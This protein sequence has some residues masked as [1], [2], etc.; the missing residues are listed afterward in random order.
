MLDSFITFHIT[1]E[2]VTFGKGKWGCEH[3]SLKSKCHTVK[4]DKGIPEGLNRGRQLQ[5]WYTQSFNCRL[6]VL[7]NPPCQLQVL[8]LVQVRLPNQGLK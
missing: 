8:R 7:H 6:S 3:T 2:A 5:A 4:D 1:Q